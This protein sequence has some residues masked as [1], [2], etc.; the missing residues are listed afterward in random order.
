MSD[1]RADT[2]EIENDVSRP[3]QSTRFAGLKQAAAIAGAVACLILAGIG[4]FLPVLPCTPFV[5]LASYLLI[6]SSPEMHLRLRRSRFFGRILRDWE[7]RKGIRPADKVRAIVI[8]IAGLVLTFSVGNLSTTLRFV[9]LILVLIGLFVII[10]L[11]IA[12][13]EEP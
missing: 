8:V 7:D 13:D 11:P 10:R 12:K 1:D 6:Q 5:L 2:T 3:N 4:F 9:T